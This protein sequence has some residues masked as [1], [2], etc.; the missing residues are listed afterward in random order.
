MFLWRRSV[1]GE[2]QLFAGLA[3]VTGLDGSTGA[4]GLTSGCMISLLTFL[5]D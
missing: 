2:V 5:M 4:A 1:D 3:G